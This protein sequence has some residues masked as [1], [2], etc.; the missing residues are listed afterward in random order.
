MAVVDLTEFDQDFA[1]VSGRKL[2]LEDLTDGDYVFEVQSAI[3]D[4]TKH[5][6]D[7][8]LKLLLY[9]VDGPS[10]D[11]TVERAYFLR[12]QEVANE[13]GADFRALGID[14]ESW[15]SDKGGKFS[16]E[17]PKAMVRIKGVR[18]KGKKVTRRGK[19]KHFHNLYISSFLEGHGP[20]SYEEASAE[21]EADN[22]PF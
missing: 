19:D 3:L 18:F 21:V 6:S 8:I 11:N 1:P 10:K 16:M 12:G 17:L 13:I 2:N 15:R 4:I 14:T 5:T 20:R 22:D 7:K 9:I